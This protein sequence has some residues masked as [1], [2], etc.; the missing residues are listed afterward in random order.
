MARRSPCS[1]SMKLLVF[2]LAAAMLMLVAACGESKED[3]AK[4]DCS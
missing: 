4:V 2:A 1:H 3:N